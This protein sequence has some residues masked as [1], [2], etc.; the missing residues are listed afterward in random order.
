MFRFCER[1]RSNLFTCSRVKNETSPSSSLSSL[2]LS[3]FRRFDGIG[4]LGIGGLETDLGTRLFGGFEVVEVDVVAKVDVELF[5][6]VSDFFEKLT[7][8]FGGG[9]NDNKLVFFVDPVNGTNG[10]FESDSSSESPASRIGAMI[11]IGPF[12]SFLVFMISMP[13]RFG[14]DS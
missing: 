6:K 7:E 14:P 11:R 12:R 2:S 13:T 10:F 9:R 8:F 1:E 5:E 4:F 3:T